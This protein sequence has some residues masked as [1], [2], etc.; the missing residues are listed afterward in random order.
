MSLVLCLMLIV[1]LVVTDPDVDDDLFQTKPQDSVVLLNSK[2]G[3]ICEVKSSDQL[4]KIEW[5]RNGNSVH[6][7]RYMVEA[8]DDTTSAL[9][10]EPVRERDNNTEIG[11]ALLDADDGQLLAKSTA[12]LGVVDPRQHLA[13]GF[14]K[15][16]E[17]PKLRTV[18]KG[19]S[20][21]LTC[22]VV[23]DPKPSILWLRNA[24]PVNMTNR[25]YS[26]STL[27]NPGSLVIQNAD[28]SDEGRYECVA[29]NRNGVTHSQSAHLYVKVRVFP[30]FFSRRPE[31]RYQ[32]MPGGSVNLSCVAVGH[33]MPRVFWR[34]GS[35]EDLEDAFKAPYGRNVL[36]LTAVDKTENYSCVAFSSL[37]NIES[38]TTVEV[39][40]L[41]YPPSNLRVLKQNSNSVELAWDPVTA[42]PDN[43]IVLYYLI[44]YRPKYADLSD[45]L[46]LKVVNQTETNVTNL[47]PHTQYEFHVRSVTAVGHSRPSR[48]VETTTHEAPPQ[49]P[50][51]NVHSRAVSVSSIMVQWEPP[52]KPNG[53]I[54]AYMVYYTSQP[55]EPFSVWSTKEVGNERL[56]TVGDLQPN[57]VYTVR[58]QARN[59]A[60]FGPVSEPVSVVTQPGIPG[61]PQNVKATAIGARR[62]LLTWESPLFSSDITGY[63]LRYNSTLTDH[64]EEEVGGS[65]TERVVENLTPNTD[66]SFQVYAK[67]QRGKGLFSRA[68]RQR[69]NPSVPSG[70]PE[71]VVVEALS[72]RQLRVIWEPP[73]KSQQNGLITG[74]R[75]NWEPL[76]NADDDADGD[77][78]DDDNDDDD[79]AVGTLEHSAEKQ[80]SVVIDKLMPYTDYQITVAARTVK[81]YGPSSEPAIARTHDDVPGAPL[82]LK[83]TPLN[84]SSAH[85]AWQEPINKNGILVGYSVHIEELDHLGLPLH[86]GMMFPAHRVASDKNET[87]VH[88]LI[89]NTNYSFRVNAYNRKGDGLFTKALVVSMPSLPPSEPRDLSVELIQRE[90]PVKLLLKWN[91]PEK[92]YAK[93]VL[94][95]RIRYGTLDNFNNTVETQFT[96]LTSLILKNLKNGRSYEFA[97]A[98]ENEQ[99][100]GLSKKLV[101]TTPT[102][103]PSGPP[104]DV[105]YE[106]DPSAKRLQFSWEPP[107]LDERNGE[108]TGYETRLSIPSKNDIVREIHESTVSFLMGEVGIRYGFAVRAKNSRG[109]GPWSEPVTVETQ[110]DPCETGSRYRTPPMTSEERRLINS[111]PCFLVSQMEVKNV[112]AQ[113]MST[114]SALVVWKPVN[115]RRVRGYKVLYTAEP[116]DRAWRDK[117]ILNPA[118]DRL[119]IE[120]L[121]PKVH[122]AFCVKTIL[123]DGA[124]TECSENAFEVIQPKYVVHDVNVEK[125]HSS[126]VQLRWEY[127]GPRPASFYV[128][129]RGKK[130][131][132]TQIDEW[133]ELS[134]DGLTTETEQQVLNV[135]N[136]RPYTNYTF[137]VGVVWL[138]DTHQHY[139]L[140][141]TVDIVTKKSVP[142]FITAPV[143]LES[144]NSKEVLLR[145]EAATE[146]YGPVSYYWLV[147]VPAEYPRIPD[148]IENKEVLHAKTYHPMPGDLYVAARLTRREI[149]AMK[150]GLFTLGDGLRY[151]DFTN[152]PL[153]NKIYY[154]TFLRAFLDDEAESD[155]NEPS[156]TSSMYSA[157]FSPLTMTAGPKMS[158]SSLWIVGPII[159]LIV[160]GFIIGIVCFFVFSLNKK[161]K[162]PTKQG[163]VNKVTLGPVGPT[164]TSRLLKDAHGNTTVVNGPAVNA[165]S[166]KMPNMYCGTG[167]GE[168]MEMQ[169]VFYP[170]PPPTVASGSPHS[171]IPV[172]EFAAHIDHLKA[173]D[174]LMFS[175]EY[176]SIETGQQQTW[177]HSNFD[178]NKPKNRYANVVAYD[179]SRVVLSKLAD[180]PGSDYINA[181]YIDGYHRSKAYIATQGPM[182]E[183][184]NDFWR[185]VW[186]EN[187]ATVVMLT[188]LEERTRIKCDQYWPSR[189]SALYGLVNVAMKDTTEL[190]HYTLRVFQISLQGQSEV[191]EVRHLQFTAWPDHGVPEHPT[192]FLIFLKRVKA[193]N[194]AESGPVIVHC[195]AGVGRTGAYIVVDTMLDRLRY[196]NTVDIYG[197]VTAIRSQR[198]YMVQTEEQYVFIHDAVLDAV[199]SGCTEVPVSKLFLHIENLLQYQSMENA[200]GMELEFRHL[201]TLKFPNA[202]FTAANRPCNKLKN[203]LVNVVPYDWSRVCLA[204]L[205]HADGSDYINASF[206]DGYRLRKMYIAT[207]G[208]MTNTV[209]DFWRMLWE[210]N[211]T[212]IV[213]LT[214]LRELGREVC[215][216]CHKYKSIDLKPLQVEKC[217]Q[218]W[219]SD[220]AEKY[221]YLLVEPIAEYNMPQYVL[222]EFKLTDSRNGQSKTIRHF[223]YT[224]WPEQGVPKSSDF[225][226]DFIGQVHKT[227]EQFGQ[228]GPI[229]VHC[230][231]G[232]SRTGVFIALSILLERIRFECVVDIFT[233]VK[234]LRA[235]RPNMVQSEDQY[236]F[237]HQAA[238]EYLGSFDHFALPQF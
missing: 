70:A 8:V 35:G 235:Q 68:V 56:T 195:S 79:S 216:E 29:R 46:T 160:V 122:Y 59:S 36:T 139:Y 55:T 157:E 6:P 182:P 115:E 100:F 142:P 155:F 48:P 234:L 202:K 156:Q 166:S 154:K 221:D 120:N 27:G 165:Y 117:E 13:P 1:G 218:Y 227:R 44:E 229:T 62:I 169:S 102:A 82:N 83:V 128:K 5:L 75:I 2:V 178:Y 126:F 43:N 105:R 236:K 93:P 225:L 203:R 80:R 140:P 170:Q 161:H 21:T 65:K 168:Q 66:Y 60:G 217:C 129:Y 40:A 78:D 18:E 159:A 228:E 114:T 143:V 153:N 183:T 33:P 137:D 25:R 231:T 57:V 133:K 135:T 95:Y 92:T 214:K 196:E 119:L 89:P 86:S 90:M 209:N 19:G 72:S 124:V 76:I 187:S 233:V 30:P 132:K 121:M 238:M 38:S 171:P 116:S 197:C 111:S 88:D 51:K 148:K 176:E 97:V 172:I 17:G 74:Y 85:V 54:V 191:R 207:Q 64:V 94:R 230:S 201:S 112:T 194:P 69:T 199:Q 31:S 185:M 14:P 200:T 150:G 52:E 151:A 67:S 84:A 179:H 63:V 180:I 20:A 47:Q 12:R 193:V 152:F 224:E 45:F 3:F 53:F 186:E 206:V 71:S 149:L 146:E 138:N 223:Q 77:D 15:V 162:L 81:G 127:D 87:V 26:I 188:K 118:A 7:A 98:A 125:L 198:N 145:L 208:P 167:A 181:N 205:P 144:L 91:E 103:A 37:G 226:I 211:S 110:S 16:V 22:R 42:A 212:I 184:F 41:A 210:H 158:S 173:N 113:A 101:V 213:M 141:Q 175:R 109:H 73:L 50:P 58:V 106:I 219:P 163:S 134:I 123:I 204:P 215:P 4:V 232:V 192:P 23:G 237:L 107:L 9:L 136:L 222:R 130:R 108:I 177:D 131:Y 61:Q 10:I 99:G 24:L 32:V 189:G 49:G 34:R 220:Q 147:V 28:E 11:C 39:K 96:N 174:N 190:A 104:Y 164:E